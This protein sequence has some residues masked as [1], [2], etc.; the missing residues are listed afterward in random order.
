[1]Q[2]FTK[3]IKGN[4]FVLSLMNGLGAP[5][6]RKIN[7]NDPQSLWIDDPYL[8]MFSDW[9]TFK[10]DILRKNK[11]NPKD[12]E[13]VT[14][15]IRPHEVH[16]MVRRTDFAEK[17]IT[18]RLFSGKPAEE[19]TSESTQQ[20]SPAYTEKLTF[21]PFKGMTPAQV[22]EDPSNKEKLIRTRDFLQ[23]NLSRYPANQKKIDAINEA[24]SLEGSGKIE[25]TETS[26][27][28]RIPIFTQEFYKASRSKKNKEGLPLSYKMDIFAETDAKDPYIISIN[29]VYA[30]L[31]SIP[32]SPLK[33]PDMKL[34][35]EG[36]RHLLEMRLSEEE[37]LQML[38]MITEQLSAHINAHYKE[39]EE[40]ADKA[41][42]ASI[43]AGKAQ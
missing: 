41:I 8:T 21:A 22:M 39:L 19:G 17:L 11:T 7:Q 10:M 12:F 33:I 34:L 14:A 36:N 27:P 4:Y 16:K 32:G 5:G 3:D 28:S 1:M 9:S 6:K 37:W 24:L 26:T 42:K 35:K 30:P 25:R 43:E 15:N 18:E 23:E 29:N 20:S 38:F 2:S 13:A 31:K 40:K